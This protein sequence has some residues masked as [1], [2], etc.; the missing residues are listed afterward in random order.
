MSTP[1]EFRRESQTAGK[2]QAWRGRSLALAMVATLVA[3]GCSEDDSPTRSNG[4]DPGPFTIADTSSVAL[5]LG[6]GAAYYDSLADLTFVFPNGAAGTLTRGELVEAPARTWPGGRGLYFSYRGDDEVQL[7]VPFEEGGATVL[8]AYERPFGSWSQRAWQRWFALPVAD[9]IRAPGGDSLRIW[10]GLPNADI[11]SDCEGSSAHWLFSFPSGTGFA[12]SLAAVQATARAFVAAWLDS[13]DATTRAAVEARVADELP[14]I[15]YPDGNYYTGFMRICPTGRM[16]PHARI[17]LLPG[18]TPG[19]VAH[20]LGHYAIHLLAGDEAYAAMEDEITFDSE[21]GAFQVGRGGLIEDYAHYHEYL[22]TGAIT[23]AG[24]PRAPQDFFLSGTPDPA[25]IDVPSLEGFGVLFLDALTRRDS[26]RVG[27]TGAEMIVPPVGIDYARLAAEILTAGAADMNQLQAKITTYLRGEGLDDR[28]ALLAASAG[29][30]YAGYGRVVNGVGGPVTGAK[31]WDLVSVGN[32]QH[33][34]AAMAATTD[35]AGEFDLRNI[36]AGSSML[37]VETASDTFDIVTSRSWIRPTDERHNLG[38]LMAW[39]TLDR[40]NRLQF[41]FKLDFASEPEDSV[42]DVSVVFNSPI[43]CSS[44]NFERDRISIDEPY[45]FYCSPTA[46]LED[47]WVLDSLEIAYSLETGYI[48][49]L[50]V[51][52]RNRAPETTRLSL[53]LGGTLQ[54]RTVA[55]SSVY[56]AQLRYVAAEEVSSLFV[57]DLDEPGTGAHT[58]ADLRG[59]RQYLEI[60]AYHG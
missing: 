28:L 32:R 55:T 48:D 31:L 59:N 60:R 35:G 3:A 56:F 13:L 8:L 34:I 40:F 18:A 44:A 36:A 46:N 15:F 21:I 29:W 6:A 52:L 37:H 42:A 57:I 26:T 17:G 51:G 54:V 23:G 19:T 25:E 14:P 38:D 24:D 47:C 30:V 39:L 49:E 9:T 16:V 10:L 11:K 7:Q 58:E 27:L 53:S 22:L 5:E 1:R 2:L 41:Q 20:Q 12:D 50:H 43:R 33:A 45:I 4:S